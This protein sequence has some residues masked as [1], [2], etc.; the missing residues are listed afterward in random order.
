MIATI[1]EFLKLE[2]AGGILLMVATAL[3]LFVANSPLAGLYESFLDMPVQVRVGQLD[4]AKPMLLW[5]NDGL[6][7]VFF[8]LVGLELKRE[9]LEGEL[10]QKSQLVLPVAAAVGGMVVPVSVF[11]WFNWGDPVTIRGWAIPAA[12]DIAFAL[13]LLTLL[14]S[15]VPT[16]LKVFLVS[17]AILDDIGA[18]A[19]IAL[20]YTSELSVNAMIFA[21]VIVG[22]LFALNRRGVTELSPYILLGIVL[23]IAVL[24]SGVHATL[25]GVVLAFF[26]PLRPRD[27]HG[28]SPLKDLEHSLHGSVAYAILPLFAFANAG[29]GLGELTI[30]ALTSP[31]ASGIALGLFIGKQAGIFLASALVIMLGLARLPRGVNWAQLYGVSVLCGVGFTM[32]LFIGGL[33]FDEVGLGDVA[34]D[35]LGVLIGSALSMILG[36]LVLRFAGQSDGE[37]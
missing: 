37:S 9:L 21:V 3:A 8:L 19:I 24:K 28:T 1:R 25:A 4:I 16:A 30:D 33:A 27:E 7:A 18:I 31:L 15:R 22:A 10:A 20:F 13:G 6:M 11:L 23:W 32:S 14:G 35:R 34:T 29:I 17:L 36:L 5:I 26:I 12:T 2:A